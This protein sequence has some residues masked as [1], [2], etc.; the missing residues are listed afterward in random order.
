M[1]RSFGSAVRVPAALL[2]VLLAGSA[3]AQ[4][5]SGS[6][7]QAETLIDAAIDLREQGRDEEALVLLLEAEERWPSPRTLA[8]LGFVHQ[9]LGHFEQAHALLVQARSAYDDPWILRNTGVVDRAIERTRAELVALRIQSAAGATVSLDGHVVGTTPLSDLYIAPGHH[10]VAIEREPGTRV[11]REVDGRVGTDLVLPVTFPPP[12]AATATDAPPQSPRD[13]ERPPTASTAPSPL[14]PADDGSVLDTLGYI[15]VTTAVVLAITAGIGYSRSA[16]ARDD[17]RSP[18]S[19]ECG[20]VDDW[21]DWYVVATVALIGS[22]T[23]GSA[24]AILFAFDAADDGPTV[25]VGLG[26]LELRAR[27]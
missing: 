7:A 5:P 3:L 8:Q 14:A 4:P 25:A 26:T 27:F 19:Y 13:L 20:D 22:L 24:G 18:Y 21:R 1:R 9:A 23:F 16:V 11:V 12:S 17:C 6:R 2:S 15:A 10:V